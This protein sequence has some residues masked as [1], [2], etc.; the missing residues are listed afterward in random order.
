MTVTKLRGCNINRG[1]GQVIKATVKIA[2][3]V[4]NHIIDK[5]IFIMS[6]GLII[7]PHKTTAQNF[8][9]TKFQINKILIENIVLALN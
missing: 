3:K 9:R 7:N 4:L 2:V 1:G 6:L 5:V 8:K